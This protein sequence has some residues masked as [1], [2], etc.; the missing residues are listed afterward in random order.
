MSITVSE[1]R[2]RLFPLIKQVN[3]DQD[4]V[5]I[6]SKGGTAYLVSADEYRSL[7]ETMYLLRSPQNAERLRRGVAEVQQRAT[8]AHE[9]VDPA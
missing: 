2:A 6:T 1:A 4:A 3:A 8:Q 7:R 9:L 5:E